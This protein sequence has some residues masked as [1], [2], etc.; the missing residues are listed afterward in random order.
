MSLQ[1]L[2]PNFR[3]PVEGEGCEMRGRAGGRFDPPLTHAGQWCRSMR[4]SSPRVASTDCDSRSLL[5]W[6]QRSWI[7]CDVSSGLM[8]AAS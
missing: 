3:D 2:S 6:Q 5:K 4:R 1:T 8:F 7:S